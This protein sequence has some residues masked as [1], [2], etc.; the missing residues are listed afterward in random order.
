[1]KAILGALL[2]VVVLA[3]PAY[4]DVKVEAIGGEAEIGMF[5]VGFV[6]G[7]GNIFYTVDRKNGLC[8]ISQGDSGAAVVPCKALMT[9]P[10]IKK[11][12][13]TG[14]TK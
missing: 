7:V 5:K 3:A 14:S 9:L 10:T 4:A 12:M 11:F 8:W 6:L 1:M 2:L 13:E